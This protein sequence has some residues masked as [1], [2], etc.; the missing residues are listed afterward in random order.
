M[1]L[2][3]LEKVPVEEGEV[4]VGNFNGTGG[5]DSL[6]FDLDWLDASG[7]EHAVQRT[8]PC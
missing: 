1:Q 6:L 8:V 3:L 2:F 4:A 7:I 5:I